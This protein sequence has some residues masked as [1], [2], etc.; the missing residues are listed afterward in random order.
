MHDPDAS[1][2]LRLGGVSLPAFAHRL[3]K[4]GWSLKLR[5]DMVHLAF[6]YSCH[7]VDQCPSQES[8]L[9]LDLRRV[10]CESGTIQ[11]HIVSQYLAEELNP[12]LRFRRPPCCPSHSQGMKSRT[13]DRLIAGS[14]VLTVIIGSRFACLTN[15]PAWLPLC[16][17]PAHYGR[18]RDTTARWRSSP[19]RAAFPV[20]RAAAAPGVLPTP[21][22]P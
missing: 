7:D 2:D 19:T 14:R 11:G 6:P 21:R 1:F 15:R 3:E 17:E 13:G 20:P 8:N 12:V 18:N 16:R 4:N 22:Q 10:A 5:L 9:I